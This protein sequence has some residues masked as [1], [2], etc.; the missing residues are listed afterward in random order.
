MRV[1]NVKCVTKATVTVFPPQFNVI[2]RFCQ[3]L[4]DSGHSVMIVPIRKS[5]QL[6]NSC[7]EL[8]IEVVEDNA[9]DEIIAMWHLLE[10][11]IQKL[12]RKE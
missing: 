4:V 12:P 8:V 1:S 7:V 3:A 11:E 10:Y 9:D 5:G 2:S 6:T